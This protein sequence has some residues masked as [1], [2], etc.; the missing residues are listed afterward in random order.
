MRKYQILLADDNPMIREGLSAMI[1]WKEYGYQLAGAAKDGAEA[2]AFLERNPCDLLITDIRMPEMSG[3]ELIRRVRENK[4]NT[5]VIVISAY[6]E[7]E[8]AKSALQY[9]AEN[10]LLKPISQERLIESLMLTRSTL[11]QRAK[12]AQHEFER[13]LLKLLLSPRGTAILPKELEEVSVTLNASSYCLTL[14]RLDAFDEKTAQLFGSDE[15]DDTAQD[16]VM[17]FLS[18]YSSCYSTMI[19]EDLMLIL[20]LLEEDNR[21]QLK[22]LIS[23]LAE[24]LELYSGARIL[25]IIGETVSEIDRL[26]DTWLGIQSLM[27]NEF[28]WNHQGVLVTDTAPGGAAQSARA[29]DLAPLLG[30]ARAMNPV[31]AGQE[32][33][34]LIRQMRDESPSIDVVRDVMSEIMFRFTDIVAEFGGDPAE[35]LPTAGYHD[36]LYLSSNN[37]TDLASSLAQT[38]QRLCEYLNGIVK[39]SGQIRISDIVNYINANY[40]EAITVK[41]LSELFYISPVYLGRLFSSKMGVSLNSYVNAVRIKNAQTLLQTTDLKVYAVCSSVGYKSIKYFYKVFKDEVGMTP[42]EYRLINGN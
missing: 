32:T 10:Y 21:N 35:A 39:K 31:T 11:D 38:V 40:A 23:E 42:H 8:Y 17:A 14:L 29:F 34:R 27:R 7:F 15:N 19:S 13:I 36:R 2:L 30:A 18:R 33:E 41:R 12:T 3:L 28:F 16:V 20:F 22:A 1:D 6:G 26:A 5:E 37:I 24:Y 25:A 9:G 4:W